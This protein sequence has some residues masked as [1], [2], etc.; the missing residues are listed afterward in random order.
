M[1]IE[2]D[3]RRCAS[4][5]MCEE[6]APDVF[7]I[8]DDGELTLLVPEPPEGSRALVLDAVAACPTGSLRLL[9]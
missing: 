3:E 8:A 9:G 1:R 4:L 2:W 7:E 6:V 5:G